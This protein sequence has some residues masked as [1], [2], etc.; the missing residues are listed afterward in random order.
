MRIG[1]LIGWT[2]P[3]GDGE[4]VMVLNESI[5][6]W[7]ALSKRQKPEW[8]SA[9]KFEANINANLYDALIELMRPWITTQHAG[10]HWHSKVI[11]H[12]RQRLV[13]SGHIGKVDQSRLET[14]LD[15]SSAS[16]HR[17]WR[18]KAEDLNTMMEVLEHFVHDAFVAPG[19]KTRLDADIAKMKKKAQPR[20]SNTTAQTP[21]GK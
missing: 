7:P 10:S 21:S 12:C 17:G 3:W 18:P 9:K 19:R 13:T 15:A 8:I 5:K 6:Y 20:Q 11:R 14:S 16:A 1:L 2:G 4:P